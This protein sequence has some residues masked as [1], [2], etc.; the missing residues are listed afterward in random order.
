MVENRI[1]SVVAYQP[2]GIHLFFG[3]FSNRKNMLDSIKSN[4]ELTG[5][6][7]KGSRKDLDV[8]PVTIANGFVDN[9]LILYKKNEEDEEKVFMKILMHTMN[10]INPYYKS[11]LKKIKEGCN[12]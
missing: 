11:S 8:T 9:G 3:T 6:Y 7:I 12:E 4:F 5:V 10:S 1:Y 2:N